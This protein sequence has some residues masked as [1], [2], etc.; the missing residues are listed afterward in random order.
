[1]KT[2]LDNCLFDTWINWDSLISQDLIMFYFKIV[3]MSAVC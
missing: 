1:M 2:S 3:S